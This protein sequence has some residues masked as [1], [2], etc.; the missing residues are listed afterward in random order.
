MEALRFET[1]PLSLFVFVGLW[2][3]FLFITLFCLVLYPIQMILFVLLNRGI[4]LLLFSRF[5]FS[6]SFKQRYCGAL[7]RFMCGNLQDQT[8]PYENEKPMLNI[9]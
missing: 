6:E 3:F 4:N 7:C 1:K 5:G 8:K 9:V 2:V